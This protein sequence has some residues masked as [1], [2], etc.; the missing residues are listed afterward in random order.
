VFVHFVLG[1]MLEVIFNP[2]CLIQFSVLSYCIYLDC[3]SVPNKLSVSGRKTN[4]MTDDRAT[5]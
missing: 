1:H 2:L 4:W 3:L 5:S